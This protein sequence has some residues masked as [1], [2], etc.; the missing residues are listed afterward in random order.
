[1]GVRYDTARVKA[2]LQQQLELDQE[3]DM[4]ME[5]YERLK[6]KM[7]TAGAQQMDGMPKS[8]QSGDRMG[9]YVARKQELERIINQSLER[10]RQ[11]RMEVEQVLERMD[12]AREKTCI[13]MKYFDRASWRDI[14]NVI[15]GESTDVERYSSYYRHVHMIH[16]DALI[17]MAKILGYFQSQ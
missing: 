7:E 8:H 12:S 3:I 13:R 16:K 9:D 5:R 2:W 14:I 1:M 15:Y 4:Q 6:A 10:Q 11:S 17:S